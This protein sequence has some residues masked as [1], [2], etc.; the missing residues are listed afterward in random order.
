V[1]QHETVIAAICSQ[2][3]AIEGDDYAYP[4]D[5]NGVMRLVF[6]PEAWVPDPTF[7]TAY[8]IWPEAEVT[9]LGP[10]SCQISSQLQMAVRACH[11]LENASENPN[12]QTPFRWQVAAEMYADVRQAI[13][14]DFTFGGSARRLV[15]NAITADY[16]QYDPATAIVD[17]RFVVEYTTARPGR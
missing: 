9:R 10:E 14:S 1:N 13:Y 15:D 6:M 17:V 3:E 4:P 16:Q 7:G 2:L 12:E 11:R 8:Y 5:A